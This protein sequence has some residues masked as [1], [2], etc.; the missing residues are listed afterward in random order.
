M[1]AAGSSEVLVPSLSQKTVIFKVNKRGLLKSFW[2]LEWPI[3]LLYNDAVQVHRFHKVEWNRSMPV[4]NRHIKDGKKARGYNLYYLE[5]SRS[6][7]VSRRTQSE[8]PLPR[9]RFET[10]ISPK[11]NCYNSLFPLPF[12]I[13]YKYSI[14]SWLI[15]E[16]LTK[17]GISFFRSSSP[18]RSKIYLLSKVSRRAHAASYPNGTGDSFPGGIAAGLEDDHLPPTSAEVKNTWIYIYTPPYVFM[19]Q[20]LIS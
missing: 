7:N 12:G 4:N 11:Y 13:Q 10:D 19:A 8:Y 18:R 1:E 17:L 2:L 15:T 20:R 3:L 5:F 14:N 16:S 9:K 6:W